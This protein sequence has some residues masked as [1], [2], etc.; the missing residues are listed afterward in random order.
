MKKLA[1]AIGLCVL[2]ADMSHAQDRFKI[3][4]DF[5]MKINGDN[6]RAR[7]F[8][9]GHFSFNF[10]SLSDDTCVASTFGEEDYIPSVENERVRLSEDNSQGILFK[11]CN[12]NDITQRFTYENRKVKNFLG[13]CLTEV[14]RDS[15]SSILAADMVDI[16]PC[17]IHTGELAST[18]ILYR[19]FLYF[20][21][22]DSDPLQNWDLD[23]SSTENGVL[24]KNNNLCPT[25]TGEGLS[26]KV[27]CGEN[28]DFELREDAFYTHVE[29]CDL[30]GPTYK[31][32]DPEDNRVTV[33]KITPVIIPL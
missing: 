22:C 10:I 1:L 28:I 32:F 13:Q 18:G 29:S 33:E 16:P 25:F 14:N 12:E 9:F 31:I 26:L 17:N 15:V 2:W 11:P 4:D 5:M 27:R 19:E 24:F 23:T 3:T 30:R 8:P 6:F 20:T 7:R 21:P